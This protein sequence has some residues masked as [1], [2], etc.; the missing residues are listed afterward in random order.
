VGRPLLAEHLSAP[1]KKKIINYLYER[2]LVLERMPKVLAVMVPALKTK[3][4]P[5]PPFS[6]G[7]TY[8]I[9]IES[10]PLKKGDLGG[11]KNLQVER[12]YGKR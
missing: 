2:I 4:P 6:N 7:G 11:F 8:W 1:L 3:I 9:S 12:I 5:S 10:P